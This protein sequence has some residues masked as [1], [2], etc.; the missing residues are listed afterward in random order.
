MV[1]IGSCDYCGEFCQSLGVNAVEFM[2]DDDDDDLLDP[3]DLREVEDE[4][5]YD[6]EVRLDELREGRRQDQLDELGSEHSDLVRRRVECAERD[7]Y[8]WLPGR[9]VGPWHNAQGKPLDECANCS[10]GSEM[11]LGDWDSSI[12]H[13]ACL[14]CWADIAGGGVLR[15]LRDPQFGGFAAGSTGAHGPTRVD[16]A[17]GPR[18]TRGRLRHLPGGAL[19]DPL[20]PVTA[21][22]RTGTG[23][24]PRL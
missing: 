23:R 7:G 14:E 12:D 13:A 16:R 4:D 6:R 15:D 22:C 20:G 10:D 18:A 3:D 5:E 9:H 2:V 17:R 21:R 1:A 8:D 19:A 24:C 11:D